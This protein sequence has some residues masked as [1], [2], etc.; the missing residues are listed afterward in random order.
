MDD[1]WMMTGG[2]KL[3]YLR[4]SPFVPVV[5]AIASLVASSIRWQLQ[6]S[7]NLYTAWSKRFYVPDPD[8]A[9]RVSRYHPIWLGLDACAVIAAIALG[10]AFAGIVIRRRERRS[11]RATLL[12]VASWIAA[13]GTAGIPVVAFASGPGPLH[14]RDTLAASQAVLIESGI[15]GSLAAPAGSYAIVSH[16]GTSVTGHLSAG[17]E[18][19]DARFADGLSGTW[20]GDPR[21][22]SQPMHAEI[23]V[24]A[25]SVDTGIRE[26]SKH[27]REG[28]L[29]AEQ[30]PRI[31]VA[32]DRVAAVRVTGPRE[33][34][35]RAPGTV[36][37]MGRTHEIEIIGTVA[38]PDAAALG[39]LGLVGDIL[40]VQ[41][42]FALA[43]KETALAKHAHDLDGDRIPI[44]VSLVLR[45]ASE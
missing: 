1:D 19:F 26:R 27:A 12:R 17:G 33:V 13:L 4:R 23:S 24:A 14:A 15:E 25:A 8:L 5:L 45:H 16:A 40:L 44:H 28:Y 32:F 10:L 37:L 2:A 35:F 34:A 42:D 43:I 9:W 11:V 3:Q 18:A 20:R 7:H 39:R 38:K 29:H 21:D 6:D 36:Q 41:A 31:T 30:Y 22:L